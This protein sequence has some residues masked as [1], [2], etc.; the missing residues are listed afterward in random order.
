MKMRQKE[1]RGDD[2]QRGAFLWPC[3]GKAFMKV[4]NINLHPPKTDRKCSG[5]F[6]WMIKEKNKSGGKMTAYGAREALR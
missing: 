4:M 1:K 3:A 5:A 2:F 6:E